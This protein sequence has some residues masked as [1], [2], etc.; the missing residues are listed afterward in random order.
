MG[1]TQRKSYNQSEYNKRAR[2]LA[3][4]AL[5][6]LILFSQRQPEEETAK[7]LSG[8][9]A[10]ELVAA[11]AGKGCPTITERHYGTAIGMADIGVRRALELI[12]DISIDMGISI[13]SRMKR[14]ISEILHDIITLPK[15]SKPR[16]NPNCE[17][18]RRDLKKKNL[19]LKP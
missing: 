11:L 17:L 13:P 10:V 3:D 7:V 2:E 12:P 8:S 6:Y 4:W 15:P 9:A 18:E 16:G 14:E 5:R 1:E 19:V